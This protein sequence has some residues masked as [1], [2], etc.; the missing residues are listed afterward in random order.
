MLGFRVLELALISCSDL[1]RTHGH[2]L[3]FVL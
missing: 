3:H 2:G 1:A